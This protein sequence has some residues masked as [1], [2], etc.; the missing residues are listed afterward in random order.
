MAG[1]EWPKSWKKVEYQMPVTGVRLCELNWVRS[2]TMVVG[3]SR[4]R[5]KVDM[6]LY[7]VG[8]LY[9]DGRASCEVNCRDLTE[10]GGE[11]HGP[12]RE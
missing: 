7:E 4:S 2:R 8:L 6:D 10:H 12:H 1:K 9:V 5:Y 11:R 3:A